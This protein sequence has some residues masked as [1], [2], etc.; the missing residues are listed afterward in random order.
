MIEPGSPE[1]LKLI[2]PS[3]V[4]AIVG[5]SRYESPYSLW[6]RMKGWTDPEPPADRFDVGHAWEPTMREL[7]KLDKRNDGWRI[8]QRGVQMACNSLGF[9]AVVTLDRRASRGSLRRVVEFK[10]TGSVEDWGADPYHDEPEPPWDYLVQVQMQMV[11]TGWVNQPAHLMVMGPRVHQRHIYEVEFRPA[12]AEGL[13]AICQPFWESLAGNTPP[14]LDEHTATYECIREQHPDIVKC[15]HNFDDKGKPTICQGVE[16][17]ADLITTLRQTQ[18][19][20]KNVDS[21]ERGLKSQLLD[22]MGDA[23]HAR[24]GNVIVADRRPHGSGSV[25]LSVNKREF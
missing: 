3:K 10:V 8:S 11:M 17:D 15:V 25:T 23:Q 9:P 22:V 5:A 7:W 18:A 2:T 6:C 14:N 16:V 13:V 20:R 21:K 12:L 24:V 1:W 19:D 4:A